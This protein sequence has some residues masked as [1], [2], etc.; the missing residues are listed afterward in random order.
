MTQPP[1]DLHRMRRVLAEP[2]RAQFAPGFADRAAARWRA[3]LAGDADDATA[4]GGV[5]FD[6]AITR[7]FARLA[8]LA[9][10]AVLLLALNNWRHRSAGQSVTQALLGTPA[11]AGMPATLDAIYGLG[12][13]AVRTQE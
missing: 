2:R 6:V 7:L 4:M 10:A 1:N 5:A 3:D 11:V 9:T 13:V 8:P 12:T